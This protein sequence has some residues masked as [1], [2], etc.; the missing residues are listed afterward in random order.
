MLSS[1]GFGRTSS[2]RLTEWGRR[3]TKCMLSG[4]NVVFRHHF[5]K[6]QVIARHLRMFPFYR[7]IWRQNKWA[8]KHFSRH[9]FW[10]LLHQEY[11]HPP[12]YCLYPY[13]Q[14]WGNTGVRCWDGGRVTSWASHKFTTGPHTS[15]QPF[16]HTHTYNWF[17]L[18][19][20]Y[21][22]QPG[23]WTLI[24]PAPAFHSLCMPTSFRKATQTFVCSMMPTASLLFSTLSTRWVF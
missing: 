19:N 2:T 7:V 4:N 13:G 8:K 11:Q 18:A 23:D 9:T 21:R 20:R 1:S 17:R 15:K 3:N 10:H 24:L 22:S 12:S 6:K 14:G 5:C 16:L